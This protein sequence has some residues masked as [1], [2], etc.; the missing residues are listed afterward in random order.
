MYNELPLFASLHNNIV[1]ACK[2]RHSVYLQLLAK[3]LQSVA[4]FPKKVANLRVIFLRVLLRSCSHRLGCA[5]IHLPGSQL[6][7]HLASRRAL[8]VLRRAVGGSK[9]RPAVL[10]VG[11]ETVI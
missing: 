5:S 3:L 4:K 9:P 6:Q 8:S 1:V 7:L 10:C 2:K 11:T